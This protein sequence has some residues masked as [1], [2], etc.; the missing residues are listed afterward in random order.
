[1]HRITTMILKNSTKLPYL[2]YKIIIHAKRKENYTKEE[3]HQLYK[4]IVHLANEAGKVNVKVIGKENIPKENGF[5]MFA[6]H[7]GMY[8]ILA[9]VETCDKPF[10]TVCKKE[11]GNIP[12]L[13][14]I[15]QSSGSY[16]MDREN[17]RD[18]M[19]VISNMTKEVKEGKNFLIFPEGTRSRIENTTQEFK[20]GSFKVAT[21]A[22]AII[23]PVVLRD[24]FIPF[25]KD[26]NKEATVYVEYLKPLYYEEYN[27]IPTNELA[28]FIRNMIQMKLD[29]Y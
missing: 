10:G 18:S 14:Q 3:H 15:L 11:L 21:K 27:S 1:M 22:K 29:N 9:I 6:N 12:F 2:A 19:T 26:T 23:L 17:L 8:D 20:G 24:A 25:D 16:T 13:K 5:V 7:Q 4:K 28:E